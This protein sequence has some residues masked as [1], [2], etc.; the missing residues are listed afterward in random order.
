MS[1]I[2]ELRAQQ[3]RSFC[4]KAEFSF[5]TTQELPDFDGM[6]GQDRAIEALSFAL[7]MNKPGYNMYLMG[8]N[9]LGKQTLLNNFLENVKTDEELVKDWCYV[10]D[11]N[12][13]NKAKAVSLS[14]G[15]GSQFVKDMQQLVV[16]LDVELESVFSKKES[17][18]R[19]EPAQV[20]LKALVDKL[21]NKYKK[22]ED[23]QSYLVTVENDL[24]TSITTLCDEKYAHLHYQECVEFLNFKNYE[25][26]LIVK[27]N[28]TSKPPVILEDNPSTE[29]L[30]GA[31]EFISQ[32]GSLVTDYHYIK[33][34]SLHQ[35]NGGFLIVDADKL[36]EQADVWDK[37]KRS[38]TKNEIK[39]P[40]SNLNSENVLL[41]SIQAESIPL[42]V[43]VILV[44]SRTLYNKLVEN[45]DDFS[46][47]F[48]VE[49]DFSDTIDC[50][51]ESLNQYAQVIATLIR[52]N[53]LIPFNRAAVECIIEYGM[54]LIEDTSQLYTHMHSILELLLE[55]EYWAKKEQPTV[56]VVTEKNVKIAIEKQIYRAD[57]SREN[58]YNEIAKGTILI[59]VSGEK[60][61]TVNGLFVLDSGRL[62]YAQPARITANVRIGDG[63]I[64]DIEREV[65]LGGALHSKV[66]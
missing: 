42:T 35:A 66:F 36:L 62:E 9:G 4:N 26:N 48:K 11:F 29:N 53:K 6:I 37:F 44:G 15:E 23:I 34:G 10:H 28:T 2:K 13:P 46:E 52:K 8:S 50:T 33:P 3:L 27:R 39:I 63:D 5:T 58:I 21:K 57:R 18:E 61:A 7:A 17:T 51:K 38:L 14:A 22:T 24:N 59:D 40:S 60:I 45:D 31:V 20:A 41:V 64:I 54:R 30:F 49:V 32:S 47:L 56:S 19:Q 43:K 55:A 12:D 16:E 25:V 1:Q 65:D